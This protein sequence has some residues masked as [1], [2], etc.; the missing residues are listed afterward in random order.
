MVH[1]RVHGESGAYVGEVS[2]SSPLA[3]Y[4]D[5]VLTGYPCMPRLIFEGN[6]V[7]AEFHF[8]RTLNTGTVMQYI[9]CCQPGYPPCGE[10]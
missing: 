1:G 9:I 2:L 8:S 4:I 6:G 10:S 7:S 3:S 5:H